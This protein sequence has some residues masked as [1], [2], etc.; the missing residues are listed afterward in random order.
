MTSWPRLT[1]PVGV[2]AKPERGVWTLVNEYVDGGIVLKIEV[3]AKHPTWKYNPDSGGECGPDGDT[4]SLVLR[5]K[6]LL[7]TAPVGAVIGKIGGSTAGA[8]DGTVFVVGHSCV[9]KVVDGGPLYFSIN[10]QENGMWNNTGEMEINV[11]RKPV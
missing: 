2:P 11:H 4:G 9:V 1:G 3:T 7:A 10:D 5:S 6:C 8:A